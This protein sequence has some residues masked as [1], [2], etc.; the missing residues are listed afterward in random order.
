MK[1]VGHSD[2]Q[3]SGDFRLNS[4]ALLSVHGL[5]FTYQSFLGK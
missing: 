3:V 5:G 1:R 2:G 4:V